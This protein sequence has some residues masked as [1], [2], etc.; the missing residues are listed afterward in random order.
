MDKLKRPRMIF[1]GRGTPHPYNCLGF[2][3]VPHNDP[4]NDSYLEIAG[5]D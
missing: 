4:Q 2:N 5:R 3:L 1:G